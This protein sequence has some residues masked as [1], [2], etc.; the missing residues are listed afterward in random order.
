[1][2]TGNKTEQRK[3]GND[4]RKTEKKRSSLSNVNNVVY[5]V[6]QLYVRR[7]WEVKMIKFTSFLTLRV[8]NPQVI[9]KCS[10]QSMLITV[11]M[12]IHRKL[13]WLSKFLGWQTG[14]NSNS[15]FLKPQTKNDKKPSWQQSG[16]KG[17]KQRHILQ[18]VRQY[19]AGLWGAVTWNIISFLT[20][21]WKEVFL[22]RAVPERRLTENRRAPWPLQTFLFTEGR[23]T[24]QTMAGHKPTFCIQRQ[25][26]DMHKPLHSPSRALRLGKPVL[27]QT[28]T[29]WSNGHLQ[30]EGSL[31]P[32]S[33]GR[34][35][36][37]SRAR[38]TERA[39]QGKWH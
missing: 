19:M 24:G 32:G 30:H 9:P 16:D 5:Y 27:P 28:Q 13:H 20:V 1:M 7:I 3:K 4:L 35:G 29:P 10:K 12:V 39:S 2:S 11:L 22:Q 8:S 36:A 14:W 38:G 31:L 34:T 15:V 18:E 21:G 17:R 37:V 26:K 23:G 6:K 25:D 33:G